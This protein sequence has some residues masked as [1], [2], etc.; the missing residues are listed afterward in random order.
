MENEKSKIQ[1]T[2]GTENLNGTAA[3]VW[4][5]LRA[6]P[7]SWRRQLYLKDRNMTVGQLVSTLLANQ[8]TPE[9]ASENLELPLDAVLEALAYYEQ[10]KNLIQEEAAAEKDFLKE[11]GFNLESPPVPR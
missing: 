6:K 11:K 7:N 2:G 8:E 10:N 3:S 1:P 4:K 5:H 9:Q